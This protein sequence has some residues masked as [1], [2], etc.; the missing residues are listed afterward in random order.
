MA[1]EFIPLNNDDT[2][3][4]RKE[5]GLPVTK[6]L[7]YWHRT[8]SYTS[9]VREKVQNYKVVA[10]YEPSGSKSLL[11]T[12]ENG[13][14]VRILGDYLV[15]MQKPSFLGEVI[16]ASQD[17][18]EP[19]EKDNAIEDNGSTMDKR[20]T[21]I[22]E[23]VKNYVVLDLETTGT[24][25][26]KDEITEIGAIRY[27]A[28]NEIARL[29]V[30]VKTD[31]E[32]PKSVERIT[33]ISN[34]MLRMLGIEA[35]EALE[36][37]KDFLGNSV[38][39][40]HNFSTFDVK[41]LE[42]AYNRELNCHFPN[43][44]IDTLYLARK[45]L[46]ELKRHNLQCLAEKYNIDYSKAHRAVEDCIINHFVYEYLAFGD[47]L[48]E[49][50]KEKISCDCLASEEELVDVSVTEKWQINLQSRFHEFEEMYGLMSNTC[51]IK[52]N[53]NDD[54]KLTSY[55]ICIYEP[56]LVEERRDSSR[57]TVLV[58][59][60]NKPLKSWPTLVEVYSKSLSDEEN[61]KRFDKDDDELV[62]CILEC[63]NIG[64]QNY[65]PKASSFACCSRYQECSDAKK[66]IHPNKLYAKACQYRENIDEGNIF[67]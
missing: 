58:R 35:K 43:D 17:M 18:L 49:E 26:Y 44:Y 15:E 34:D 30:F 56:D 54:G 47:C 6:E 12:L 31:V 33:G 42:D 65:V 10:T 24:N 8:E 11:I 45:K 61:G 21:R 41:F 55:A 22:E 27:E 28:G 19:N 60:K 50:L 52:A 7:F 29:S 2:K 63:M 25:H 14:E 23:L 48:S 57:N 40:G 39:V 32:I 20:A 64:L 9:W 38:V 62:K 51:S 37:L 3:E 59:V 66:C 46:P 67:Y 4:L 1:A 16:G 13:R 36:Q 5:I 53:Y